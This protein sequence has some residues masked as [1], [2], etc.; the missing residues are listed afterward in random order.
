MASPSDRARV[1]ANTASRDLIFPA[2]AMPDRQ[3][4]AALWP[5][6]QNVLTAVGLGP[7]MTGVDLCCGDGYF[8]AP[9]AVL[10]NAAVYGVDLDPALLDAAQAEVVRVGAPACHWILGDARDLSRLAPHDLD[11]VLLANTFHG[12]P[13]KTVLAREVAAVLRP[14]GRFVVVNWHRRPREETVVSGRPR[15]PE[16]D[17][18]MAPDEVRAV[19]EPAGFALERVVELPPYHYG[20]IFVKTEPGE[21]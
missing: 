6:P 9:L 7:N 12:A 20:A 1:K 13:E 2:T 15:G 21:P 8:T 14:G 4:W 17:L 19:V 18:R 5:E 11:Y 10:T 16:S 3:W